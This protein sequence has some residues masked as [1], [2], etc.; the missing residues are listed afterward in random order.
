MVKTSSDNENQRERERERERE[1]VPLPPIR[2]LYIFNYYYLFWLK[3]I[4]HAHTSCKILT[5]KKYSLMIMITHGYLFIPSFYFYLNTLT[6]IG[7]DQLWLLNS[8]PPE[9]IHQIW[10]DIVYD[11]VHLKL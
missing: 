7:G 9:N 2:K 6:C 5:G 3:E 8:L 4:Y 10:M 1:R 11:S